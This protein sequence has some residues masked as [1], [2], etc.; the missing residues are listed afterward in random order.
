MLVSFG[1]EEVNEAVIRN[2]QIWRYKKV[3]GG[4][5]K[6]AVLVPDIFAGLYFHA[7]TTV[8]FSATNIQKYSVI[9]E[10]HPS[11]IELKW[12]SVLERLHK[13]F[14]RFEL[15][16]AMSYHLFRRTP[17][18]NVFY[19][20][21]GLEG[22]LLKKCREKLGIQKYVRMSDYFDLSTGQA[23][24]PNLTKWFI[25]NLE[26]I[27]DMIS[28]GDYCRTRN[29]TPQ[30]KEKPVVVLRTRNFQNK[31]VVHN[32][33]K[34]ILRPL[35]IELLKFDCK[36]INIGTPALPLDI[37]DANYEEL[38]HNMSIAEEF[39]LCANSSC[40]IMT[41]EAGNY[42]GLATVDLR[43]VQYDD[44]VFESLFKSPLSLMKARQQAGLK[45][46]DIRHHV[47]A[48][49]WSDAAAAIHNFAIHPGIN[50]NSGKE[51]TQ[52]QLVALGL[53]QV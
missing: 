10:Y 26:Y 52:P 40:T 19:I 32:S 15:T 9:S 42:M 6:I 21:S 3:M 1:F 48:E 22:K 44:E 14:Y 35:I 47:K 2:A 17:R 39:A 13:I 41:T 37:T 50:E 43:M 16:R 4:N 45:D 12:Y 34:S 46:L 27:Q 20:K 8:T 38:N 25:T 53:I 36:V 31:A 33:K 51:A 49:R 28:S 29:V 23:V 24:E 18:Q 5:E 7:D 30:A 11:R